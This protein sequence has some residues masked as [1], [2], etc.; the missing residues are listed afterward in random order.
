MTLRP[1]QHDAIAAVYRHLRERDDA[2]VCVIPTGGGKSWVIA[3]IAADATKA[4]GGR[5][6]V[7]A[8]RRE[9][10]TQNADKLQRLDPRLQVGIYSAGLKARE[11][12]APT[13]V[14][15]IQ[16]IWKKACEFEPFDLVLIDEC[17]L[18]DNRDD[19]MYGSFL[20]DARVIN[21]QL[22]VIGFTAT[23]YRL[24][25]GPICT[26]DGF[27]NHICYEVGVRELI[28]QGFLSPLV[29][30]AGMR[31]IDFQALHIRGG[32]FV[33]DETESLMDDPALVAAACEEIISQT[34]DRRA[35]LIFAT[36]VRHGEHI[37]TVLRERYGVECGFVTGETPCAERD[38]TLQ[39]FQEG[40][41]KYL[42]NINVLSVGFD[43]PHID[44]VALLRPT[45]SPGLYYQLVGRG[46]RLH[47][48]KQNCLVLD[49]GGNILRHGP[50]DAIRVQ[51]R[52]GG[53]GS[54]PAKECPQCRAV[55]AAGYAICPQCGFE[56][57]PPDRQKHEAQATEAGILSGQV[58]DVV[59]EVRDIRYRV[60]TKRDAP[61]DAPKSL[62]VDYRVG[63]A[64]WHSEFICVEHQGY[65]RQKAEAWWQR[66]SPDPVPETAERA[67][68][69]AEAGALCHT[70]A[71][72]IRSVT[73]E[74][75]D[76]IIKYDL[77]PQP[78]AL[79]V[80]DSFSE[81]EVPF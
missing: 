36:G 24:K 53:D 6:L 26:P 51:E 70:H 28:V 5:V 58:T 69:L 21:P 4:W 39:R 11:R 14:A 65:A 20:A 56:F 72:T 55:I 35:V 37:V 76:R 42:V 15:G 19:S 64:H 8:H 18:I 32:E 59:Y 81:D 46:F 52:G 63:L 74:K 78:D 47:P 34:V 30:K 73:G 48:H 61:A 44:C 62:R 17:H 57:P 71:I 7:L 29:T 45:M 9:L 12:T 40:Q 10:L 38:A 80:T 43:A 22:R 31:K 41:L 25:T 66:R 49:F 23:P 54:A 3:Q 77:G 79:P 75:F 13:I 60:H 16:S 67:V 33:A 2:P 50:V 1:Y 27:L 68:E